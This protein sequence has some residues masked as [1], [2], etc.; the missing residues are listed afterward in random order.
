MAASSLAT[1]AEEQTF[2]PSLA[3]FQVASCEQRTSTSTPAASQHHSTRQL[4][5]HVQRLK[6]RTKL[7]GAT[8]MTD[9]FDTTGV[10][11]EAEEAS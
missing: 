5:P 6:T 2:R 3:R 11:T 8:P 9:R 10:T 1:V 4:E 7:P